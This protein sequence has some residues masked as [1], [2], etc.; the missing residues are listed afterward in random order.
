MPKTPSNYESSIT[1]AKQVVT[2]QSHL[3]S[4]LKMF[5]NTVGFGSPKGKVLRKHVIFQSGICDQ[6]TLLSFWSL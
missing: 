2:K 3:V 6:R 5:H 1:S 4:V